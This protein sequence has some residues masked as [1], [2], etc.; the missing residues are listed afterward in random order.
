MQAV[1]HKLFRCREDPSNLRLESCL[2]IL[3]RLNICNGSQ[4]EYDSS[5]KYTL[6]FSAA[7]TKERNRLVKPGVR[8]G[9]ILCASVR[10]AAREEVLKVHGGQ[11]SSLERSTE[12]QTPTMLSLGPIYDIISSEP[13]PIAD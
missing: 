1:I 9:F 4:F 13:W 10:H 6:P 2:H 11:V 5:A 7:S 8:C 3:T 12:A